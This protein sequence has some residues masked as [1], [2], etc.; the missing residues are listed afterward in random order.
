M[1]ERVK[2][3]KNN[4]TWWYHCRRCDCLFGVQYDLQMRYRNTMFCPYCGCDGFLTD[5]EDQ[6]ERSKV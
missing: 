4:E 5:L 1:Q 3:A 6:D 2:R